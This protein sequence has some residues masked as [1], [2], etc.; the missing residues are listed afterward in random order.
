MVT[1]RECTLDT[2]YEHRIRVT[3]NRQSICNFYDPP[4]RHDQTKHVE[5]HM[6]FVMGRIK[7][8]KLK[9]LFITSCNSTADVFTE[10]L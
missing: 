8:E 2:N 1:Q 3:P 7:S 5:S 9:F 4:I 10:A 6:H